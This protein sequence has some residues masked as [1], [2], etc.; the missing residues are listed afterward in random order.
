MLETYND[1]LRQYSI[2]ATVEN[3]TKEDINSNY[4]LLYDIYF[5]TTNS[6]GYDMYQKGLTIT[7]ENYI[8]TLVYGSDKEIDEAYFTN[9][10]K[11]FVIKD[12]KQINYVAVKALLISLFVLVML[13]VGTIYL[14]KY[15]LKA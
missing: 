11:T 10:I 2:N 4:C 15:K 12:D 3:M 8:F 14:Y 6:T 13:L 5:P 7:T 1:Y 9:L